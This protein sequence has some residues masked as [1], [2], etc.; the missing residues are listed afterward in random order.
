MINSNAPIFL[1]AQPGRE[2]VWPNKHWLG[3][4]RA[5]LAAE[6]IE[7]IGAN[8]QPEVPWL[9]TEL[10]VVFEVQRLPLASVRRVPQHFLL[11][12]NFVFW[13]LSFRVTAHELCF[14]RVREIPLQTRTPCNAC[15]Y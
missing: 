3:A 7:S 14:L 12:R 13:P 11:F 1:H 5:D 2:V 15:S 8:A 9:L 6:R 4:M 10:F